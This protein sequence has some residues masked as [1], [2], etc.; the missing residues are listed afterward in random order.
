MAGMTVGKPCRG[1]SGKYRPVN[2]TSAP[3]KWSKL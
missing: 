1:D 3:G 2:L